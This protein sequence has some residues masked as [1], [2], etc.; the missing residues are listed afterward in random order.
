[1]AMLVFPTRLYR[2]QSLR[3]TLLGAALDGGRSLAGESQFADFAAGGIW[4]VE[5]G[6]APAWRRDQVLAWRAFAAAADSGAADVVVPLADRRHQPLVNPL[7]TS[8]PFGLSVWDD[9]LTPWTPDQVTAEVTADAALGDTELAC[10]FDGPVRLTG[11]E[12]FSILHPNWGW[13]LHRITRVRAGGLGTG[14]PTVVDFRPPLR[15]A[16]VAGDS[17]ATLLNFDSPRCLMHLDGE[18]D[19]SVEQLRF[20]RASARF[21]EAGKPA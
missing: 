3:V 4:E 6:E 13:R 19:L 18:V 12:H 5:F 7:S 20:G 1:M 8:D 15:E 10:T 9:G 16:I 14:D 17:P 11:G 21:R 2:P